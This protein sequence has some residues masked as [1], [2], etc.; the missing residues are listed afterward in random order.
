[1][2][3]AHREDL[4]GQLQSTDHKERQHAAMLLSQFRDDTVIDALSHTLR[5]ESVIVAR[6]AAL[7]LGKIGGEK[8][9]KP[10]LTAISHDSLWVRKAAIEALGNA[11]DAS[12]APHLVNALSD[13]D[14]HALAREALIALNLNPDFF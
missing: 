12:V 14:L 11:G 5:D 10:L 1:M 3:M 6:T 4:L 8:V 9:A 2:L 7:S 13:P